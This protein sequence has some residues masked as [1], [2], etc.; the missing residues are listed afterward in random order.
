MHSEPQSTSLDRDTPAPWMRI[1]LR[2]AGILGLV[3]GSLLVAGPTVWP[4]SLGVE[5]LRQ[6]LTWQAVGLILAL[7]GVAYWIAAGQPFRYWPVAVWGMWSHTLAVVAL[8]GA[9]R[10]GWVAWQIATPLIALAVSLRGGFRVP[11]VSNV[12]P[13]ERHDAPPCRGVG[14]R[15]RLVHSAQPS[16]YDT[17]RVVRPPRGIGR[18]L[19]TF[20]LHVLSPGAG[21]SGAEAAADRVARGRVGTGAH[22]RSAAGDTSLAAIRSGRRA[23]L[24]RP[25]LRPLRCLWFDAGLVP[26]ALRLAGV[27]AGS[28]GRFGGRSR[29]RSLRRR[30]LPPGRRLPVAPARLR[31]PIGVNPPRIVWT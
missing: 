31:P 14:F 26:S 3:G 11:P 22:V 24:L 10:Q 28:D 1:G 15:V 19:A 18:V 8:V 23:S 16:R 4:E 29:L 21:R 25:A 6:P 2:A 20:R 9:T 30:R 5:L 12:S 17:W 27:V 7:S 13:A